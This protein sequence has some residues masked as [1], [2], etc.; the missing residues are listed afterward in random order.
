[1]VRIEEASKSVSAGGQVTPGDGPHNAVAV[2]ARDS[3]CIAARDKR[4]CRKIS[5]HS[6]DRICFLA[7][8]ETL[9]LV[10]LG[11]LLLTVRRMATPSLAR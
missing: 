3:I 8:I 11:G 4:S 6:I 2:E 1:M 5:V 9:S 7:Y 10:A